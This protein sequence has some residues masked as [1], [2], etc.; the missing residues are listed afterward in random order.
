MQFYLTY[1]PNAGDV[2][3]GSGGCRK[4]RWGARGRGKRGGVYYRRARGEMWM[5]TIYVKNEAENIP[6]H[7]L[8]RLREE[9]ERG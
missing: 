9:M 2:V 6:G 1:H 3:K 5:L 8:R 7:V 4:L